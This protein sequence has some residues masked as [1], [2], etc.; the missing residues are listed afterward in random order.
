M[1][2][3]PVNINIVTSKLLKL[4]LV[5]ILLIY[6]DSSYIGK[7]RAIKGKRVL[8]Q[9]ERNNLMNIYF[10]AFVEES[11]SPALLQENTKT[12]NKRNSVR[13]KIKFYIRSTLKEKGNGRCKSTK[14]NKYSKELLKKKRIK[15]VLIKKLFSTEQDYKNVFDKINKHIGNEDVFGGMFNSER[16]NN[17]AKPL[18]ND[19]FLEIYNNQTDIPIDMPHFEREIKKII[20]FF[21]HDNLS[22]TITFVNLKEMENINKIRR[23]KNEPTDIISTLHFLPNEKI[24]LNKNFKNAL[25]KKREE[26]GNNF[27]LNS[28]DIFL[29]PKYIDEK[30]LQSKMA[31]EK[32]LYMSEL[33]DKSFSTIEKCSDVNADNGT[34]VNINNKGTCGEEDEDNPIGCRGIN[35]VFEKMFNVNERLPFY[36]IHGLIHL[37]MKDHENSAEEY[38]DFMNIEE[39]IIKKYINCNGYH[40]GQSSFGHHII[41]IGTDILN[42][43]RIYK[44]IINKRKEFLNIFVKKVLHIFEFQDLKENQKILMNDEKLANY[45]GKKFAAKEAIVKSMGR[46]VSYISQHGLSMNDIEIRNDLFGKPEIYLYNK[47]KQVAEQL[48]IVKIFL[49]ITDEKVNYND[50]SEDKS[51]GNKNNKIVYLIHAQALAVGSST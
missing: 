25:S 8:L 47:T 35:R 39:E 43:S 27:F 6:R 48:G 33:N 5:H 23:K 12:H 46:G 45:I 42:V 3:A 28:G 14:R 15:N 51:L 22:L 7:V 11:I 38:N 2:F 40:Y 26:K 1:L 9:N 44:M 36:V 30:C 50:L 21:R 10:P 16:Y 34:C 17:L 19:P 32:K 29:C 18:S 41:G 24:N 4:V 37:M 49:S 20:N 13:K 31:Y